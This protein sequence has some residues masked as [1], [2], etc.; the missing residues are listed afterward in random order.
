M[1]WFECWFDSPYYHLLYG[2]RDEKEAGFFLDNLLQHLKLPAEARCW[3]LN[4]G[5]GR[6]SIYLTKKGFDVVG[7]DLSAES[8]NYA[9]QFENEHLHFYKHD[10]RS[11]FYANYFDAV[12]NIF[13]SFG[14]F[15]SKHD[16]DKVFQSVYNSL[17]PGGLFVLDYFNAPCMLSGLK[18]NEQKTIEGVEFKLHKKV[19]N[20]TIYKEININDKGKTSYY[21]E[22]VKIFTQSDFTGLGEKAG[23]K[24]KSIFGNYSLQPFDE[25]SSERLI[26]IFEK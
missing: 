6:H 10:M 4:C 25:N 9:L 24:L 12:F 17:K 3:D 8:I 7:T 5:K 1:Q 22:E 2:K 13:T 14:Y 23:F 18:D 21:K 16:D 15:K 26:L 11:L 19:E 20:K